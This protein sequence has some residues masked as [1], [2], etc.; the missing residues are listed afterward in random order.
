MPRKPSLPTRLAFQTLLVLALLAALNLLA[1]LTLDAKKLWTSLV[2]PSDPRAELP[3]YPDKARAR[4]I[5]GEFQQLE[6]RYVPFVEWRRA[7]YHGRATNVGA[8][9]DRVTPTTIDKP[10]GTVR[11]FGGSAMWG[12]GVADDETIPAFF[13]QREP[14]FRV[15]NHGESGFSTRQDLA[16][17]VN[18]VNQDQ[19]MDV[20]VFYDGNNDADNSCRPEVE[21]NGHVH[22]RKMESLLKPASWVWNDLTGPLLELLSGKATRRLLRGSGPYETRCEQSPEYVEKIAAT[23]ARNWQIARAVAHEGGAEFVAVL[24]PVASIGSPRVDH[25]H[26]KDHAKDS[27]QNLV[28]PAVRRLL[29]EARADWFH[30]FTD[31]FDGETE[32]TYIDNCHVT[33]NG[34]R[35]VAERIH[36]IL[37]PRLREIAA[38]RR[39][40]A[41]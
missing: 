8:D 4:Q 27:V 25:L 39:G 32:Y 38:A 13:Q 23:M 30:D 35:K 9:G 26:P 36:G 21:I 40:V 11:F 17:L 12:T 2:L 31:T 22:A 16:M 34:T 7:E 20:V 3:N 14:E 29:A 6:T 10:V 41:P 33:A 5:L 15:V 24:Q 28:Y 1:A 18:L 37:E 19:P